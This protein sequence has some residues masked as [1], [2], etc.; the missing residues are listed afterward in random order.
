M[1][2]FRSVPVTPDV[3][4]LLD[5]GVRAKPASDLVQSVEAFPQ[6][7]LVSLMAESVVQLGN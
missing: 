4:F 1:T 6:E 5:P 3:C 2:R 7:R